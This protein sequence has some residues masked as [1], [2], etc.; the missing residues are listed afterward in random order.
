MSGCKEK[1][2]GDKEVRF[3]VYEIGTGRKGVDTPK[4]SPYEEPTR[5]EQT[6]L[7]S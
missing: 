5:R 1:G 3:G 6:S 2:A 7:D 4:T